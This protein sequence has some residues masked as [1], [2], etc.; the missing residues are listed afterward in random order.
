[1]WLQ[2]NVYI[3]AEMRIEINKR[4]NLKNKQTNTK[5]Q[6]QGNTHTHTHTH[7][8]CIH[9]KCSNDIGSRHWLTPSAVVLDRERSHVNCTRG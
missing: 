8:Q 9:L 6:K 5:T 1:M 3:S 4:V 7:T 2:L